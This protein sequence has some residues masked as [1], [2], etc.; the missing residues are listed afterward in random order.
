MLV[1]DELETIWKEAVVAWFKVLSR[2]L[3]GGSKENHKNF[4]IACLRAE[5]WIRDLPNT[6]QEWG[7]M[8][9]PN[10]KHYFP[11]AI[12][13]S[14]LYEVRVLV[15]VEYAFSFYLQAGDAGETRGFVQTT[16]AAI[17]MSTLTRSAFC[18]SI[19]V[20][21]QDQLSS[22]RSLWM[23]L[24]NKRQCVADSFLASCGDHCLA[25][26]DSNYCS[27]S[28]PR[29]RDKP[30]PC[31]PTVVT[32][33]PSWLVSVFFLHI[34]TTSFVLP[35]FVYLFVRSSAPSILNAQMIDS[36]WSRDFNKYP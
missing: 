21:P 7:S 1:N 11:T 24:Q 31:S 5:I 8:Y 9:C 29:G 3:P 26:Y 25:M 14:L 35:S 23:H 32:M 2:H 6:E 22:E 28:Y 10:Y 36:V 27:S 16:V 17:L 30:S 33:L 4:K 18:Q 15:Y 12:L 13:C 19:L 20:R 34:H